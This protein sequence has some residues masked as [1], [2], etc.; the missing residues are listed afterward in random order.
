MDE[1]SLTDYISSQTITLFIP[2]TLC[3]L[4]FSRVCVCVCRGKLNRTVHALLGIQRQHLLDLRQFSSDWVAGS[5]GRQGNIWWLVAIANTHTYIHTYIWLFSLFCYFQFRCERCVRHCGTETAAAFHVQVV[6]RV[7]G[8]HLCPCAGALVCL[9]AA[10]WRLSW[11]LASRTA[12][13]KCRRSTVVPKVEKL[14]RLYLRI[15]TSTLQEIWA[16]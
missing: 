9:W 12:D 5:A 6:H 2:H 10:M 7:C 13:R 3:L 14:V 4:V 8:T 11:S 16:Y 1:T 15:I